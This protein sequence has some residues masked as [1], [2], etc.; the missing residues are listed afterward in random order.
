MLHSIPYLKDTK[1]WI[2]QP[3]RLPR[4]STL[5]NYFLN[6]TKDKIDLDKINFIRPMKYNI[7]I[8]SNPR[9][10]INVYSIIVTTDI[11]HNFIANYSPRSRTNFIPKNTRATKMAVYSKISNIAIFS[12]SLS[13]FLSFFLF[14]R[15]Q[16]GMGIFMPRRSGSIS[17]CNYAFFDNAR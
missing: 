10:K 17:T 1:S 13:F 11:F 8:R 15:Y 16:R 3:P 14:S 12:L 4:L 6:P 5:S 9:L 2:F 7:V